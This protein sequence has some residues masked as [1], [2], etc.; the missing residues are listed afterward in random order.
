MSI[1]SGALPSQLSLVTTTGERVV[2]VPRYHS[3]A[4]GLGEAALSDPW[5]FE[6]W[7]DGALKPFV[8]SETRDPTLVA[9]QCALALRRGETFKVRVPEGSEADFEQLKRL[10]NIER[11]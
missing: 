4:A 5:Y 10:G 7:S 8:S 11:L 6:R 9:S 1:R 2:Y 3:L